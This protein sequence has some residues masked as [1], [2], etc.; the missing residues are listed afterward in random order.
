MASNLTK[1]QLDTYFSYADKAEPC[2]EEEAEWYL[3]ND[4]VIP[5]AEAMSFFAR[6][7]LKESGIEYIPKEQRENT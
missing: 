1:E 2:T 3:F 7:W 6:K 4:Y 5:S